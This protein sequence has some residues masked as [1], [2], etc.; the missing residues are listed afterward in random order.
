MAVIA[1]HQIA[2]KNLKGPLVVLMGRYYYVKRINEMLYDSSK[3]E[4]AD[5]K[6]GTETKFLL[7]EEDR[8]TAFLECVKKSKSDQLYKAVYLEVPSQVLNIMHD[9]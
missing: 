3:F 2:L 4:E 9:P 6:P 8:L 5:I 7:Q 1:L